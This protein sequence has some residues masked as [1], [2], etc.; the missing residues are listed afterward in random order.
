MATKK[1]QPLYEKVFNTDDD[2]LPCEY[3]KL[4]KFTNTY[5]LDIRLDFNDPPLTITGKKDLR[6]LAKAILAEVGE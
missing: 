4:Y 6:E 5:M 3:F 1:L 2:G